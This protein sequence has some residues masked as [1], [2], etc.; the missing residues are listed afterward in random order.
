VNLLDSSGWLEFFADGPLAGRFSPLLRKPGKLLV[1]A[2][3]IYEVFKVA[4]RERG[5]SE[6]LRVAGAMHQGLV[7]DVTEEM[8]LLAARASLEHRLPMADAMTLTVARMHGATLWTMDE[9]FAGLPQVRYFPPG[10]WAPVTPGLD[11]RLHERRGIG[12]RL[13]PTA[14]AAQVTPK[15]FSSSVAIRPSKSR[16]L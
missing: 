1:P 14:A 10:G 3:V 6:A 13:L 16:S 12:G 15:A 7:V 8:A 4:L 2:V 5:E 11:G 9:H